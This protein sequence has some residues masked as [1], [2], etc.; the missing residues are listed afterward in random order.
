MRH[1][2][3]SALARCRDEVEDAPWSVSKG[4]EFV[5]D[6]AVEAYGQCQ[7]AVHSLEDKAAPVEVQD[8]VVWSVSVEDAEIAILEDRLQ[9]SSC[10]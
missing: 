8:T 1:T 5:L 10:P 2:L 6:C 4:Q 7:Y 9:A 3:S